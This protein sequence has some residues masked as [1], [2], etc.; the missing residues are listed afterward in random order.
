MQNF[1]NE[2]VSGLKDRL[3]DCEITVMPKD[4]PNG[5]T[6]TGISIKPNGSNIAPTI[7]LDEFY[8]HD[9][10]VTDTV[11]A[12]I[13]LY[14]KHKNPNINVEWYS[15]FE[16]VRPQLRARLYNKSTKA[17][18][19]RSAKEYGFD[20]LII[21]PYVNVNMGPNE[22]GSIKVTSEHCKLWD[23][24]VDEVIDIALGN[25][26]RL[27]KMQDMADFM[28]ENTGMPREMFGENSFMNIINLTE[29]NGQ[30][31][32][33]S[34]VTC[35]SQLKEMYPDGYYVIPSSIHECIIVPMIDGIG[36][37]TE[38]VKI[39][40]AEEIAHEEILSDHVYEV[41]G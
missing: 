35:R 19:F 39:V 17:E 11:D 37:L 33:I 8:N 13:G 15:D 41:A 28:S 31:G 20:D 7:Y 32:A 1:V 30:Y 23:I 12:I 3:T 14:E 38:M 36:D 2:V 40:N 5:L 4:L 22:G 6:K 21:V 9:F 18:V 16:Q 34:A 24:S 29:N 27:G 26:A 25:V 10:S